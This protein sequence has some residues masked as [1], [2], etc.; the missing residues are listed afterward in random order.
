MANRTHTS[1]EQLVTGGPEYVL[2]YLVVNDEVDIHQAPVIGWIHQR[3]HY[4]DGTFTDEI[5]PGILNTEFH[6][7]E[8]AREVYD[9]S[10]NCAVI[11]CYPKGDEP[12]DADVESAEVELYDRLQTQW[13]K[14]E[15]IQEPH[16]AAFR[17][18]IET[19][20]QALKAMIDA[21]QKVAS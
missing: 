4:A 2:H 18:R 8:T 15:S 5:L 6:T 19:Q 16:R 10:A 20:G 11:G 17:A 21:G 13:R 1:I 9:N 3:D 12:S 7:V 14:A